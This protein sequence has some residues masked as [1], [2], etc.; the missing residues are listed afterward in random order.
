MLETTSGA[1]FCSNQVLLIHLTQNFIYNCSLKK[2]SSYKIFLRV[3]HSPH[4]HTFGAQVAAS[5]LYMVLPP[6][7]PGPLGKV[8]CAIYNNSKSLLL[9]IVSKNLY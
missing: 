2:W 7:I 8:I 9:K 4:S 1:C 5:C 3:S 6:M